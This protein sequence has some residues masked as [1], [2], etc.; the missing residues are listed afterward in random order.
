MISKNVG[1][2][3]GVKLTLGVYIGQ[4]IVKSILSVLRGV[5]FCFCLWLMYETGLVIKADQNSHRI[6]AKEVHSVAYDR[7]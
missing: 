2:M 3:E 1:I 5:K 4:M 6:S 7:N